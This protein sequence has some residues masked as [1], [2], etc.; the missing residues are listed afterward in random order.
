MSNQDKHIIPWSASDVQKYLRGE[1]SS[2][3][4]H[5]LE[6]AALDD[7]FLADAIEGL[8]LRAGAPL[9]D[10]LQQLQTRLATRV[11]EKRKQTIFMPWMKG[12]AAIALL[13]GLCFTAWYTLLDHSKTKLARSTPETTPAASSTIPNAQP[14]VAAPTPNIAAAPA[15]IASAPKPKVSAHRTRPTLSIAPIVP[16]G[17][18]PAA[19]T[20]AA[21]K[22]DIAKLTADTIEFHLKNKDA[23]LDMA[24]VPNNVA[25]KKATFNN[26]VF[27]GQVLDQNK[28]PLA[29]ASLFVSGPSN[30]ITTTNAMGQF[31]LNLR[32]QDTSQRLTVALVGYQNASLPVNTLNPD[33]AI[34][35]SIFLRENPN[36]LSEVVVTGLGRNRKE[37][38]AS[39]P[40]EDKKERLD[41]DWIKITP[42]TGRLAYLQYIETAKKTL[43]V[44]S[45]IQGT[46]I[47]SFDIDPKGVPIDFK[48]EHS[49]SPAHDAGVIR[50]IVE[51]ARWK[52]LRS[53][54]VRAMVSVSFP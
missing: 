40:F 16:P 41:A 14:S 31:K 44:D 42:V 21:G 37:T 23:S 34:G 53:K 28:N 2:R 45:S 33:D 52:A 7:P 20:T 5:Q 27:S 17:A 54:N 30:A 48:I 43:S 10:D 50:L 19:R 13:A 38:F 12:A 36:A 6:K 29:G 11:T 47:I 8:L 46:E 4:M 25:F 18:N 22:T 24:S 3:E 26:L 39:V 49:L 9:E 51:G 35:N 15:D 1:L 32:P